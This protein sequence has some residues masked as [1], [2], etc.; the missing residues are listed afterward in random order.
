MQKPIPLEHRKSSARVE[1]SSTVSIRAQVTGELDSVTFQEGDDVREGQLLFSLDQ[2]PL[3]ARSQQAEANLARDTA[4]AANAATQAQRAAELAERGIATREQVETSASQLANALDATLAADR[5]AVDNARVQL[6]YA[7]IKAP[8]SG[9]TGALQVHPGNLVR[10]NDTQPLVVINQV[11]AH[12][13]QLRRTRGP[14]ADAEAVPRQR[15]RPCRSQPT[16][17]R[18][19]SVRRPHHLRR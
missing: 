12:H 15:R 16:L 3:E 4:Q 11:D 2:R 6:Q 13:R 17:G 10:A 9:R 14:A 18:G 5:A 8:I 1:P 19:A 7:T